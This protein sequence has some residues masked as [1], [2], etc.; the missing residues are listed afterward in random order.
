LEAEAGSMKSGREAVFAEF[1]YWGP[2]KQPHTLGLHKN[3]GLEIVYISRGNLLWEVE[4]RE[5]E[6][7]PGSVFFTLPWQT[8]GGTESLQA[9]NEL[10]FVVIR[11]DKNYRTPRQ[12]FHFAPSLNL[13]RKFQYHIADLLTKSDR[14]CFPAGKN[15]PWLLPGLLRELWKKDPWSQLQALHY[16]NCLLVDLMRV[17][18]KGETHLREEDGLT[19]V[20]QYL[21]QI[22][23]RCG[24]DWSLEEMASACFLG[25]TRFADYVMQLTGDGPINH[26]NRI[27]IEKATRL[28]KKTEDSITDIGFKCGFHSSQ[29]F[30]RIF[31]DF[32][33][34]S[35]RS[36]R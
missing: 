16:T 19:R 20:R 26:L 17:L 13:P 3:P 9:N 24:D 34:I 4:G 28:L 6:V 21:K 12:K 29:Y 5:E 14:H 7:R 31:R 33:G 35:P 25:R 30:S 15:I 2:R 11:L 36:F 22:P 18:E 10:Y 23:E 27:R 1:G 32:T 8:H